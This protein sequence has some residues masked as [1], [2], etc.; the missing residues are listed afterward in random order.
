MKLPALLIFLNISIASFSQQI[1]GVVKDDK[2]NV[3]PNASILVKGTTFGCSAN[4]EGNFTLRL[5]PGSY[6]LT[7]QHVGYK[8]DVKD[9]VL[10][11]EDIVVNFQLSV[12]DF[13]MEEVIVQSG[14]N[15]ARKI[16]RQTIEKRPYYQKQLNS[17]RCEVYTKGILRL[18]DYPNKILGQKVDFGDGDTS[19]QKIVYLSETIAN[20]SVEKPRH[21]KTEVLSSKVSGD[22][23]GYGLA[24]PKYYSF[25]ENN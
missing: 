16:I 6:T 5:S 17:F 2:G 22:G 8:R 10:G 13:M 21:T 9:I 7:C 20:Y 14:E 3:L 1:S 25:Y 24:A 11:N 23:D 19:K 4:N 15:P 12:I 18:R